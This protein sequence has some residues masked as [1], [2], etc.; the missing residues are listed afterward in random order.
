MAELNIITALHSLCYVSLI[1]IETQ[2]EANSKQNLVAT[3][4]KHYGTS[5]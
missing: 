5:K 2:I 4:I 1:L 3:G